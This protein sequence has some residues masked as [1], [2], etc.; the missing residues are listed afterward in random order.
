MILSDAIKGT[1]KPVQILLH[2]E[3]FLK[4][5]Q[6]VMVQRQPQLQQY[7]AQTLAHHQR[8]PSFGMRAPHDG[9]V[10][11]AKFDVHATEHAAVAFVADP[12]AGRLIVIAH[13]VELCVWHIEAM[14]VGPHVLVIPDGQRVGL[15]DFLALGIIELAISQIVK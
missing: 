9:E 11:V 14:N 5:V 15:P 10:V 12:L 8:V 7:L 2:A 4:H 3:G 6:L 13:V 1:G